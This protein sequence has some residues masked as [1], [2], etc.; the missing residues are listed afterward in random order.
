[1]PKKKTKNSEWKETFKVNGEDLLKK[2][3]EIIRE[4]NVRRL[5]I[6]DKNQKTLIEFPLTVGVVIGVIAPVLA[7]IGAIAALVTEC[8]ITVVRE[9]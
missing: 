8:S 2:V 4:G 9:E 7:A 3:K 5:I 1:M 6:Q